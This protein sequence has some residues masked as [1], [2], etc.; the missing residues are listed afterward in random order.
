MSKLV[1][2]SKIRILANDCG[3]A[4]TTQ[5]CENNGS[6]TWMMQFP[7]FN[8]DRGGGGALESLFWDPQ[9]VLRKKEVSAELYASIHGQGGARQGGFCLSVSPLFVSSEVSLDC[10][11]SSSSQHAKFALMKR[12]WRQKNRLEKGTLCSLL[13]LV[14]VTRQRQPVTGEKV[15]VVTVVFSKSQNSS[16]V[17]VSCCG[18]TGSTL[19]GWI[20][21]GLC[22]RILA[23]QTAPLW[24]KVCADI[25]EDFCDFDGLVLC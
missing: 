12:K 18:Q 13:F 24:R 22:K 3:Y 15:S 5:P 7:Y 11:F 14:P 6:C 2:S 4:L 25:I 9:D 17:S 23:E 20:L 8:C 1:D 10:G 16:C 19:L 21:L